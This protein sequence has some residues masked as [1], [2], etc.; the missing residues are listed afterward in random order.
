MPK[1]M[2]EVFG[3]QEVREQRMPLFKA[4]VAE[5][6]GLV[7]LVFFGCGTANACARGLS[8]G[9]PLPADFIT[10]VSLAFGLTI[11]GTAQAVGH[12]SGGH[13]NPAVTLGILVSGK[14]SLLR[15]VLYMIA[16]FLGGIV[17]AALL[18]AVVPDGPVD[19]PTNHLGANG[20]Q[21]G[22]ESYQGMIVEA[23][24]TF[25]LVLVVYGCC[26][27]RRDD[28]KGSVPLAIGLTVTLSHLLS[29]GFTGAGLNPARTLGPAIMTGKFDHIWVY[30]VGPF[31]GA[32]IAG[33]LYTVLFKAKRPAASE[34]F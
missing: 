7:L 2:D 25:I 10:C 30:F 12:I 31:L 17:G 4:L 19:W 24:V 15:G 8:P 23:M 21:S 11:A 14:L 26:D 13:I 29:I 33:I 3:L 6:L 34:D 18:K 9:K 28:V 27:S 16:Q 22:V 20:L 1:K 5:F 32:A